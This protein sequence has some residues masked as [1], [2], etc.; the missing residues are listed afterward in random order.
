MRH[1]L[2]AALAFLSKDGGYTVRFPA[3]AGAP[4]LEVRD[5]AAGLKAHVVVALDKAERRTY[6]VTHTPHMKG[7]LKSQRAP[8]LDA[9]EKAV[10]GVPGTT[11]LAVKDFTYAKEKYS[12]REVLSERDGN[13]TRTRFVLADPTLYTLVVG[14]P[15]EF[16]SSKTALDFLDSLEIAP[17]GKKAKK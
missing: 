7:V 13:Q 8:V 6:F 15:K 2:A 1:Q 12:V 16:A 4:K 11:K 3:G 17:P 14:G 10:L 5:A 9:G